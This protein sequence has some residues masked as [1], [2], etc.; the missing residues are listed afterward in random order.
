MQG[1]FLFWVVSTTLA[2]T[3]LVL[4]PNNITLDKN[5][6]SYVPLNIDLLMF[7]CFYNL[8][9]SDLCYSVTLTN[10]P[11]FLWFLSAYVPL[12]LWISINNKQLLVRNYTYKYQ[13]SDINNWIPLTPHSQLCNRLLWL[14][15][16]F[17]YIINKWNHKIK[18]AQDI[19][20]EVSQCRFRTLFSLLLY[21]LC[22]SC[23]GFVFNRF[24]C[25]LLY[26]STPN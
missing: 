12:S 8:C 11:L 26:Q 23:I 19:L 6:C 18:R 24:Y 15:T 25:S 5:T 14:I 9:S 20:H 3:Y 22:F 13:Q 4:E 21:C 17:L 7:L 16:A 10:I 1:I 2:G